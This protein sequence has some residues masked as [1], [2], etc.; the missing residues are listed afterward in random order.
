MF[1]TCIICRHEAASRNNNGKR[2]SKH[3]SEKQ[4][5]AS[6]SSEQA[7]SP[8]ETDSN[9]YLRSRK[10][11]IQQNKKRLQT[12]CQEDG[13]AKG[14][15]SQSLATGLGESMTI[16]PQSQAIV[17]AQTTPNNAVQSP[18]RSQR[19]RQLQ[20]I[21][22]L[23]AGELNSSNPTTPDTY[24]VHFP[25]IS[26]EKTSLMAWLGTNIFE[27]YCWLLSFLY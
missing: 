14:S 10:E 22:V 15:S 23:L 7:Q 26:A 20:E 25:I 17:R 12:L 13:P 1:I 19:K 3:H 9:E 18:T 6:T 21:S 27:W 2:K 11:R 16:N 8:S 4:R 24:Y 5:P